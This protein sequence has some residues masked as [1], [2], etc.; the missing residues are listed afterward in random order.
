MKE[1]AN[2]ALAMCVPMPKLGIDYRIFD[3][4]DLPFTYPKNFKRRT[5]GGHHHAGIVSALTGLGA[6][7][8]GHDRRNHPPRRS[9]AVGG[10]KKNSRRQTC[11]ISDIILCKANKKDIDEP[12]PSTSTTLLF[13]MWRR[14]TSA[15]VGP[16]KR[17]K[18]A[19][20]SAPLPKVEHS[21]ASGSARK[22]LQSDVSPTKTPILHK[23]TPGNHHQI[24]WQLVPGKNPG[25]RPIRMPH[26]RK[27]TSRGQQSH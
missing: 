23:T 1:S 16:L 4:T 11:G 26:S 8:A 22:M 24:Y 17:K 27:V 25:R 10:S 12:N 9:I 18:R 3:H 2:I 5:L 21:Y 14:W 13:I 19:I 20:D 7:K 15:R 6:E